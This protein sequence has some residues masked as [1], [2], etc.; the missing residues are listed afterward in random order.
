V[1]TL[2]CGTAPL[3]V[4][5]SNHFLAH[6]QQAVRERFSGGGGGFFLT[7]TYESDGAETTTSHW[8]TPEVA[9]AF[10][11]DV[12]DGDGKAVAPV[13]I[14]RQQVDDLLAAMDRPTGVRLTESVWL[15]FVVPD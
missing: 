9:L 6:L 2:H 13:D 11:Y 10:G 8:V 12:H 4:T 15:P 7:G 1:A 5:F 3:P 14:D